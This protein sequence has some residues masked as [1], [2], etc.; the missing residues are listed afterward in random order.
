[1]P[2]VNLDPSPAAVGVSY[3]KYFA[4]IGARSVAVV[5]D[6]EVRSAEMCAALVRSG[7]DEGMEVA[8]ARLDRP[9]VAVIATGWSAE[10]A[11]M[12]AIGRL[13]GSPVRG[14]FLAPWL[15]D[16]PFI[17][18][19]SSPATQ[20]SLGL[21]FDPAA[22]GA[23]LYLGALARFAPNEAPTLDGLIGYFEARAAIFEA[24]KRAWQPTA[25]QM[26]TPARIDFLPVAFDSHSH[27]ASWLAGG[28]GLAP[29]SGPIPFDSSS[30]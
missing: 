12:N 26:F 3:A 5:T 30:T 1:V 14:I 19:A 16:P 6:G 8:T 21:T 29:V 15:L 11:V 17:D 18:P 22:V 23:R 9:D 24:T 10:P 27:G 28:G 13:G 2:I 25:L 20:V 7:R 4:D